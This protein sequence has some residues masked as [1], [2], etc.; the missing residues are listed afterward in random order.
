MG[1][2]L[3]KPCI[4]SR[5]VYRSNASARLQDSVED[6]HCINVFFKAISEVQQDIQL[7]FGPKQQQA[8]NF[9]HDIPTFIFFDEADGDW[10]KLEKT[11]GQYA[12]LFSDSVIV[13]RTEYE[14]WCCKW[15]KQ[16]AVDRPWTAV[17]ALDHCCQP[18]FVT[19]LE[20]MASFPVSTAEAERLLF[21]MEHTLTAIRASMEEEQLESLLFLQVHRQ[22]CPSVEA[23]I[24]S[25]AVTSARHLKF[26]I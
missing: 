2:T 11:V 25:F 15:Q 10:R 19:V 22:D 24:D 6:Y 9:S 1:M 3:L 23:V 13:V 7:C 12:S 17:A 18:N 26:V 14:L 16:S 4:V 21:R 5:S 20:L 8:A